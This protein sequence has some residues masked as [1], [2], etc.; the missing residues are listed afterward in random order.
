MQA[1]ERAVVLLRKATSLHDIAE[2]IGTLDDPTRE[3]LRKLRAKG[4]STAAHALE[5]DQR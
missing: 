3:A 2:T 1:L 4:R 5:Q